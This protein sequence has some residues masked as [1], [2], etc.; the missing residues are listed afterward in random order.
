MVIASSAFESHRDTRIAVL[1][2]IGYCTFP[3]SIN[4]I[5]LIE[6]LFRFH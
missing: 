3:Q 5:I 6:K 4:F 1:A 2:C